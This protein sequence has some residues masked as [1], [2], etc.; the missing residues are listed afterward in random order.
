MK[1]I[2]LFFLVVLFL[3]HELHAQDESNKATTN[4]AFKLGLNWNK[5]DV[6]PDDF[7]TDSQLGYQLG[8]SV[9][10]GK[11]LYWE[12]GLYYYHFSASFASI[13]GSN[14]GDL[15]YSELKVPLLLGYRLLPTTKKIFN[16]RAFG[17]FLPGLTVGKNGEDLGLADEQFT[18]FHFDPTIGAD[19]DI[20][21]VSARIGYSY[22]VVDILKDYQSHPSY[23]YLFLGIGF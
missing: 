15:S 21:I 19:V 5:P 11:H 16:L 3:Q 18:G 13:A 1:R 17:G 20:L 4:F 2:F 6:N 12:T 10:H 8:F 14:I 7:I 9:L 22:G 23:V